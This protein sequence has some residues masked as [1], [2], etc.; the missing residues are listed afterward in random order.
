MEEQDLRV[1]EFVCMYLW[2][3]G[4]EETVTVRGRGA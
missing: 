2:G 1:Y 4:Y 3:E